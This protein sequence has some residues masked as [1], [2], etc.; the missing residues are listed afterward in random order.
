MAVCESPCLRY[1]IEDRG[2]D[3]N[4]LDCE[5]PKTLLLLFAKLDV[6]KRPSCDK[7]NGLAADGRTVLHHAALY[8]KVECLIYLIAEE[9]VN[10]AILDKFGKRAADYE[11]IVEGYVKRAKNL[12]RVIRECPGP[13]TCISG[14]GGDEAAWF[15]SQISGKGR[16]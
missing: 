2:G 12:K 1:L 9:V 13:V 8:G 5:R 3:A 11:P 4:L 16:S 10:H 14:A 7:M 6:P 15:C